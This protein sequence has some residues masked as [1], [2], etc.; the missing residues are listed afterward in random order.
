[1][2]DS[3]FAPYAPKKAVLSVVRRYRDTGLT[4]PLTFTGLESVGIPASTTSRTLQTL[5]FLGLVDEGGNLTEA[6]KRLKRATT[7]EYP[8]VLAEIVRAAYL[9]V[10]T[11]VDPAKHDDI[12]I[13]DAFRQ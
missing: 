9:N 10:F 13:A 6:A 8:D 12:A 3:N 11:I 7:A 5:R 1:M 4:E 2:E